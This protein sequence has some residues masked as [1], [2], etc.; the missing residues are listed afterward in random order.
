MPS[1]YKFLKTHII[2]H[3]K[4]YQNTIGLDYGIG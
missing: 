4:D 2:N 3:F 1:Y